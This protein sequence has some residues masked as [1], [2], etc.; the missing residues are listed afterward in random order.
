LAEEEKPRKGALRGFFRKANR[1]LNRVTNPE[2]GPA[3]VRVAG[4]EIASAQ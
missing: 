4:F 1:V 3:S 2:Q